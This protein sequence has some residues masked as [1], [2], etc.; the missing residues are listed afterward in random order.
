LSDTFT[1]KG[2]VRGDWVI[3]GEATIFFPNEMCGDEF[4][5]PM[6]DSSSKIAC[7]EHM[8]LSTVN[9]RGY[10]KQ[11]VKAI[12]QATLHKWTKSFQIRFPFSFYLSSP[13]QLRAF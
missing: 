5:D 1:T 2:P 4:Y 12:Y 7:F 6:L 3:K 11:P 9:R 8:N 10:D 13:T